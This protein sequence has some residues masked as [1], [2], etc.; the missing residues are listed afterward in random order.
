MMRLT[1][2]L[3]A[4]GLG[5]ANPSEAQ[6]SIKTTGDVE[7]DSQLKSNLPTGTPPLVVSSTT[8]VGE[9]RRRHG[10]RIG[11]N[12]YRESDRDAPDQIAALEQ[13]V[14]ENTLH[15]ACPCRFYQFPTSEFDQLNNINFNCSSPTTTVLFEELSGGVILSTAVPPSAAGKACS[16]YDGISVVEAE[17]LLIASAVRSTQ[18][19]SI[20]NSPA[21]GARRL[22]GWTDDDHV[23]DDD[24]SL[25]VHGTSSP[26]VFLSL[27]VGP[28]VL[29]SVRF[30]STQWDDPLRAGAFPQERGGSS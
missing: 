14:G 18:S 8:T 27:T 12:G 1:F 5:I 20:S 26:L 10:R 2:L 21:T 4:L 29:R 9:S 11:R 3:L 6:G 23:A 25:Q 15:L 28:A 7:T 19:P 24:L 17:D 13:L 22:T 30:K 16:M